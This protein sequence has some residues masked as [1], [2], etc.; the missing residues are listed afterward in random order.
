MTA[1]QPIFEWDRVKAVG[2]AIKS[3]RAATIPDEP[4]R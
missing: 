1:L 3:A 4:R 2:N